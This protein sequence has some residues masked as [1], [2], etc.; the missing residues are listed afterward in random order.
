MFSMIISPEPV[1]PGS[2][3]S[4]AFFWQQVGASGFLPSEAEE[5]KEIN[6]VPMARMKAA[7]K[8]KLIFFM[9]VVLHFDVSRAKN[10]T[11]NIKFLL[12]G[13]NGNLIKCV[14]RVM[15]RGN[16]GVNCSRR[17]L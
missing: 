1:L 15:E 16:R 2:L 13:R 17:L 8:R 5:V 10:V 9:V 12:R 11:V 6:A 7:I 4:A 14:I 3:H